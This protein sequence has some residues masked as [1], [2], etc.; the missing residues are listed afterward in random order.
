MKKFN[1]LI[2]SIFTFFIFTISVNAA[3]ASLNVSNSN[4][5]VG[6]SFTTSVNINGAAAWEI[7]VSA[8]G[9]VSGCVI[10][11]ADA[12]QNGL[13][14]NT[15]VSATCTATGTG[16]ITINLL[17]S[18]N[19][20]S[21]SDGN[22]VYVS[23]SRSVNVSNRPSAPVNPPSGGGGGGGYTPPPQQQTNS[24]KSSNN[25]LKSSNVKGYS[26]KKENDTT[27]SLT[28]SRNTDSIIVEAVAE[29][30]KTSITHNG[31]NKLNIGNNKIEV[32]LTAENGATK[33]IVLNITRREKD[34]ISD[35]NSILK[36]PNKDISIDL[37]QGDIL[38]SSHLNEIKKASKKITLNY[39]IDKKVI[40]GWSFKG[41]S[42]T[43]F[44]DFETTVTVNRNIPYYIDQ[45]T[46]NTDGLYFKVSNTNSYANEFL[47]KLYIGDLYKDKTELNVYLFNSNKLELYAT[48]VDVKDGYIEFPI[49]KGFEFIVTDK[50]IDTDAI[51]TSGDIGRGEGNSNEL[52][53]YIAIIVIIVLLSI[54]F[55]KIKNNLSKKNNAK[56]NIEILDETI[57]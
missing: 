33:T 53:Y 23:G 25:N 34:L 42:L 46:N 35:L 44:N 22:A 39:I 24:N 54:V 8:S 5:Y 29:D 13:D 1:Y 52:Y 17:G 37:K 3:G 11:A 10:N 31:E 57:I 56:E 16:T 48:K 55:A 15:S 45:I 49:N 38:K 9:P 41:N 40:Y 47:L 2:V 4:V 14:T 20:V 6:D 18:S 50:V 32:I 36:E 28:V 7:H 27:Y 51:V 21:A 12:T 19:V 43:N 26:L 30:S